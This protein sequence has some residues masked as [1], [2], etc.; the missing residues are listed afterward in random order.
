MLTLDQTIKHQVDLERFKTSIAK[1]LRARVDELANEINSILATI[2]NT[3]TSVKRAITE[4]NKLIDETFDLVER[5]ILE[6]LRDWLQAEIAWISSKEEVPIDEETT[7]ALIA[8]IL[9][10]A[11]RG[12][13]LGQWLRGIRN[14]TKVQ[15][16]TKVVSGINDNLNL[17]QILRSVRGT[18]SKR[19]KDG[20]WNKVSNHLDAITNTS[21]QSY[22]NTAKVEIWKEADVKKYMWLSVLDNRTSHICRARSNKIYIV[23]EG[24]IPPAHPR[25]RSSI[26]RYQEGMVIPESYSEWLRKQPRED[27]EDILGKGKANLFLSNKTNLDKFITPAGREL[28]LTELK[29]RMN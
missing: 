11:V 16:R 21:V 3:K 6:Q 24:P 18:V 13:T 27:V 25:C 1:D 19:F 7:N 23:G 22:S 17:V 20:V 2:D 4:V 15:V 9:A 10:Q 28:T 14:N 26:I 5:D 12:N 8:V 29:A